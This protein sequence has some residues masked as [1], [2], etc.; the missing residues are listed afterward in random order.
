M[1]GHLPINPSGLPPARGF[2]HGVLAGEGRILHIAGETGHHQD[3]SLDTGFVEQ[4]A[5]AC[6]NVAAVIAEAG[7]DVTDL[8][9]LTIYVTDVAQYRDNLSPVGKAYQ[10]VF[11]K[12]FPAMALIGVSG[13]VDPAAMVEMVGVAIT[14][15]GVSQSSRMQTGPS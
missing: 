14:A 3:L 8:V 10:S 11:G 1:T 15:D 4:F 13:L 7:G 5:Q 12:H 2:S 9:S 6:R